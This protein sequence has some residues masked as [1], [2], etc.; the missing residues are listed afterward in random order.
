MDRILKQKQKTTKALVVAALFLVLFFGLETKKAFAADNPCSGFNLSDTKDGTGIFDD[1]KLLCSCQ[2]AY[3]AGKCEGLKV[4]NKAMCTSLT[5]TKDAQGKQ[6]YSI[7]YF[8]GNNGNSSSSNGGGAPIRSKL[9]PTGTGIGS[10]VGNTCSIVNIECNF[11][12]IIYSVVQFFGWLLA[13]AAT[14]FTWVVD[15]KNISGDGGVLNYQAIQDIWIMVRDTLNMVFILVLLFAAF[16]TVFQIDSWNL[17]KVWLSV[18]INALLV[19]FSFPIARFF[20]DVSN[21][22]MYYFLGHL[23]SGAGIQTGSGILASLS[24]NTKISTLLIPDGY[25]TAPWT[26][27]I[28][29]AVFTFI[30]AVT[31]LVLAAMFVIRLVALAMIVMFSPIGFVSYIFP[32]TKSYGKKWWNNLFKY[33][34]FGPI[35]VFIMAVALKMMEA[36]G[37][38]SFNNFAA[39]ATQNVPGNGGAV[40]ANWIAAAAFYTI[41]IMILWMGMGISKSMGIEGAGFV[42]GQGQKFAKWAGSI[43]WRGTKMAW[44]ATGIPGGVKQAK[45]Y[46]GKRGVKLPFFK[47]RHF[48]SDQTEGTNAWVAEKLGVRNAMDN[49]TLKKIGE[50]AK[51]LNVEDMTKDQLNRIVEKG[52]AYERLAASEQL[53]KN[54]DIT[55][56]QLAEVLRKYGTEGAIAKRILGKTKETRPDLAFAHFDDAIVNP[57]NGLTKREEEMRKFINSDKFDAKKLG[58]DTLKNDKFMSQVVA[59]GKLDQK[60]VEALVS[61]NPANAEILHGNSATGALGV[62][63]RIANAYA[64]A[65]KTDVAT[66]AEHRNVQLAHLASTGAIHS[67][68][69]D[70]GKLKALFKKLNKDNSAGLSA[71]TVTAN[72]QYMGASLDNSKLVEVVKSIKAPDA[73]RALIR[74]LS[75]LV[76]P[77]GA[78]PAERQNLI[79]LKT[80]IRKDP[81]LQSIR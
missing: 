39:A 61:K 15:A 25:A 46:Y 37:D 35:M 30:L 2:N 65:G 5:N 16:C 59:E 26:Y 42:V 4:D 22:M 80:L 79:Q 36:M 55:D 71:P 74:G 60:A 58:S 50:A 72:L 3:D 28:A 43:P 18:L 21:V 41:P 13:I 6:K 64:A 66:N 75:T 44:H 8:M 52:S 14:L 47:N 57:A 38:Q 70:P 17:K 68:I 63:T 33:S 62:T 34:F 81:Y 23:F 78:S 27:L 40:N 76:L 54:G 56:V 19:N 73:R 69:T 31:L 49:N 51:D 32:D 12:Y 53:A 20:I 67:S 9:N 77:P 45:D 1:G 24:N 29:A 48:G 11:K 10:F 7:C